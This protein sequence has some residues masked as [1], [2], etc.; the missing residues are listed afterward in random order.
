NEIAKAYQEYRW[1]VR[2]KLSLG[3][4]QALREQLAE[5]EAKV[6]AAQT[7]VD[8]LREEYKISDAMIMADA[9]TMLMSAEQLRKL[10]SM[11][12]ELES[13]V[14]REETLLD[15]LKAMPRDKLIYSLPTASPDATLTS[16]VEQKNLAEQALIVKQKDY[17]V[18]H[19]EVV[20][21]RDQLAD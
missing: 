19:P 15:S 2:K 14:M 6:H 1:E 8:R 20:K 21:L 7:N 16:L 3:G 11:R 10:E 4:I 13:Q 9:P 18:E 12:I 5:H 17:G